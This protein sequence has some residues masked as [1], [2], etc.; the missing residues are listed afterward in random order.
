[1]YLR[2]LFFV[3]LV[4]TL[5]ECSNHKNQT[6][7]SNKTLLN[8]SITKEK[9][10]LADLKNSPLLNSNENP[11]KTDSGNY[12][13]IFSDKAYIISDTILKHDT[14]AVLNWS[15]S[16]KYIKEINAFFPTLFL[17]NNSYWVKVIYNNKTSF[18]KYNDIT[19]FKRI[20]K[21]AEYSVSAQVSYGDGLPQWRHFV[22]LNKANMI[23]KEFKNTFLDEGKW[24]DNQTFLYCD[25]QQIYSYNIIN[26][27]VHIIDTGRKFLINSEIKKII[28]LE[29][30]HFY[31]NINNTDT[32]KIVLKS[33]NYSGNE[34]NELFS[35]KSVNLKLGLDYDDFNYIDLKIDKFKNINCYSF[36]ITRNNNEEQLFIDWNGNHLWTKIKP[37]E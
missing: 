23:I 13:W 28:Y 2:L 10:C 31:D 16:L 27:N 32:C 37:N 30:E 33:I 3:I 5:C 35:I 14:I 18:V 4:I 20:I 7:S 19:L 21:N 1:M 26:D 29:D 25:Y 9:L 24:L 11:K 12:L 8:D 15:D 34:K 6:S 36:W 22:I 17:F